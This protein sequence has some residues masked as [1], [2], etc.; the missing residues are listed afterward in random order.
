MLN[1]KFKQL[2]MRKQ[3]TFLLKTIGMAL[4][5]FNFSGLSAQSSKVSF[6]NN[7]G[8][9]G[10]SLKAQDQNG[11]I[12]NASISEYAI[13][14]TMVDKDVMQTITTNGVLLQNNE[15]AP[16]LPL[17]SNYIAVP[18]GA[19]VV[20]KVVRKQT[21]K[22]N[23]ISVA[24]SPIIPKE[25][26][27]SPLT[28]IKDEKI[29]LKDQFYPNDIVKISKPLKIRGV[30][31]VLV[32]ISPFQYNP[33]TKQ[34]VVNR[35][36]E[37]EIFFEGGNGEFGEDRLRNRW[38]DPILRDAVLNQASIKEVNNS[39][40]GTNETGY[41]YLIIVPDDPTFISWA[42]SLKQFRIRQGI[43]TNVLTTT[44]LGGNTVAAIEG[45]VDNAYNTWDVPPVAVLLMADY[46]DAG[47]TIIS[48]IYDNYCVSDNIFAD[49]DNDQMPDVIFA[50][51][52]AQNAEHL[53]TFVTKVLNYERNPP[54]SP[55]FYNH[56]ITALGWQ[57]ERWFQICSETVG[58]FFKNVQGK[59][60]VR[61]N[62]VYIGDP[63]SDPWSSAINTATVLS[64]FGPDGLGYIPASP[65]ELGGWTGGSATTVNNAINDGAFILQHRDH[66]GTTGWG[67]PSYSSSDIV[68]LTNTDLTF[69]FSINCLTG[70]YN[71]SG[72]CF[73]EKFHRYK[74]DG[75]NSGALGLIAASEVSYSFVNDTYVWGLY[76]NMW[77]EFLPD[78]GTNPDSRGVLPAFG[79]A[80]GKYFLQQSSWPYNENNKEVTYNLFHHHGDAFSVVYSEVPQ[81]LTVVHEPVIIEGETTF[82]ITAD[83]GAFIALSVNNEIIGTAEGTGSSLSLT[84]AAQAATDQIVVI[85]TKQNYYRHESYVEIIPP[86]GPYVI[87]DD[88][89]INDNNIMG[90]G[91][92]ILATISMTNIG[93]EQGEGI[94]VSISTD[95][96]YIVLTDENE[97][98]GSIGAGAT[99]AIPD[100]YAWEVSNNIP[101]MHTVIFDIESTDG[102]NLW[103]SF[104]SITGHAPQL[105]VGGISITDEEQG[106]GNGNLD[107]G[108]T[109][110]IVIETYNDGSYLAENTL[111]TLSSVSDFVIINNY[112]FEI[113]D[114]ESGLPSTAT[115]SVTVE[116]ATPIGEFIEFTYLAQSGEYTTEESFSKTLGLIVE[117]WETGDMHHFDWQSG[118]NIDWFVSNDSPFEGTY[119]NQSGTLADSQESW[120]SI[121]YEVMN[122]DSISFYAMVSSEGSSDFFR[123]YFDG[124]LILIWSGEVPW[125]RTV[126]PVSAGIHTFKWEYKKDVSQSSGDDCARVD[127]IIFPESPITS[128]Y[129]GAD[130]DFCESDLL[131]CQGSATYCDSTRWVTDGSGI[132]SDESILTPIYQPSDDDMDAGSVTLTFTGY[133]PIE[134]I[135]DDV[136]FTIA[137]SPIAYSGETGSA[138]S[139]ELFNLE[140]AYA[141]NY[142]AIEWTTLGDGA[143]D[144]ASAVNPNYTVGPT[145]IENGV[146]SLLMTVSNGDACESANSEFEL[147][148]ATATEANAGVDADICSMLTYTLEDATAINYADIMWTT[149]GDGSF[150][151]A[152]LIHPTYNPGENDILTKEV[153]LT[154]T[155]TATSGTVCPTIVDE[156]L[157]TLECTDIDDINEAIGFEIFPNPNSG[158]F[159]FTL[160][161][162]A[163]ENAV[164]KVF[165]ST[166]KVVYVESDV[167]L[168]NNYS[169]TINLNVE[170]GI[171]TIRVEGNITNISKKFI[172]K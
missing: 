103:T 10:I 97:D 153:T 83:E 79:N 123:F 145:D 65:S 104:M 111:G 9:H 19:K 91:E 42:D 110:D 117:D 165:S 114:I 163:K 13:S 85:V 73:A 51:M 7:W 84:I 166:G 3:I 70:K 107:P 155:L 64:Q 142:V 136:I 22:V 49:V 132:F 8:N 102:T 87:Y 6:D 16:N 66:G 74:K 76:D 58:G 26:D 93:I 115:F 61:I 40:R 23:N 39:S 134:T 33:V 59:D 41:E 11:L 122:D 82:T 126:I 37:V 67:E 148:V 152:T 35:D 27:N 47:N 48:P 162:V 131:V 112:S 77:P 140:A 129:A 60:P 143:F 98:Y 52:T 72:E 172:V 43:S 31:V 25:D 2:I 118:G 63:N 44:E 106:N 54:I 20:A 138:C 147:L 144:D 56:P 36:V 161:R 171:Y 94:S 154:L 105:M 156:M 90:T 170:P 108:E 71:I 109:V 100:G 86:E 139:N 4:L 167:K 46:G 146:T 95:D 1:Y 75:V 101:D 164:I 57:T 113:G 149:T 34:M 88:V 160:D 5:V 96:D 128:A 21:V 137:K 30:D 55:D 151:D 130:S 81:Y 38:W 69:I 15:G 14:E 119:C 12:I 121:E 116:Q 68:G 29:Y 158:G 62:A 127:Y 168:I 133:G 32:A 17:Y 50:R 89:A 45:Y 53:E 120:L 157:L 99:T 159:N 92:S 141:E 125:R 28:F 135:S 78:F 18:Q 150:D 24:P 80:A 124:H 169:S